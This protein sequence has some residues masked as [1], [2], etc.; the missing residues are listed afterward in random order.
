MGSLLIAGPARARRDCSGPGPGAM[1]AIGDGVHRVV[2]PAP[3]RFVA[4]VPSASGR[5]TD[6]YDRFLA[7]LKPAVRASRVED[8]PAQRPNGPLIIAEHR[9]R[10]ASYVPDDAPVAFRVARAGRERQPVGRVARVGALLCPFGGFKQS[11]LGRALGPTRW[12]C[13]STSRTSS[14]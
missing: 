8:G 4:K 5:E 9:A 1:A 10:V 13:S 6:G 2:D 11:G 14:S 3:G 12:T 7:L